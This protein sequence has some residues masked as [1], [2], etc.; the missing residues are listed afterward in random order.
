MLGGYRAQGRVD[1]KLILTACLVYALF[2]QDQLFWFYE[3]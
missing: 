2:I 1:L 3:D